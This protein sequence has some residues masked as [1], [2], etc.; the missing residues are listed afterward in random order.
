MK[1]T[2]KLALLASSA[3][4]AMPAL[5]QTHPIPPEHYVLDE[6]G[7]D[8]VSGKW[9]PVSG[10]VSI[11]PPGEGLSYRQTLLDNGIWW[12]HA[13]GG[14]VSCGIGVNCV[15]T[16]DGVTE[17]FIP[18]GVMTFAS[19]ENTG[20]TL[21]Y[22]QFNQQ[23]VY[24]RSDGTAY[25]MERKN[26]APFVDGVVTR[27]ISPNGVVTTYNYASVSGCTYLDPPEDDLDLPG[28]GG[29]PICVP[30]TN[31]RL[32][33]YHTNTGYMIHYE[34]ASNIYSDLDHSW[35]ILKKATALNLAVDACAPLASTCAFTQNWPSVSLSIAEPYPG[36]Q[37]RTYTDQTGKT[38]RYQS[39]NAAST[40]IFVGTD[41]NPV[42]IYER[43]YPYDHYAVTNATGRW[44]YRLSDAG[45]IRTMEVTGP[46]GQKRTLVTD[47]TVGR[48][49]S[50][51]EVT[52]TSPPAS[53]TWNWTYNAGR[54]ATATSPEGETVNYTYD[55]RG[56]VTQMRQVAKPGSGLTDITTSA[57]YPAT[58]ANVIICNQP[59]STT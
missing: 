50:Y 17:S 39:Q 18:T 3:L 40:K 25:A 20:S 19:K 4:F 48:P 6:R 31:S 14:I 15:I 2:L 43:P 22:H 8:L 44:E 26:V 53:R 27:R 21:I 37:E 35:F 29:P 56:N 52:S 24:T 38:I 9:M 55:A 45:S 51:T 33:S 7:M 28:G 59:T 12:D 16:V 36:T 1:T 11:G 49:H 32:Q 23:F 57:V 47:L 41:P 46:L 5:A 30:W 10:A 34:Y 54:V 42:I 13:A 58:C